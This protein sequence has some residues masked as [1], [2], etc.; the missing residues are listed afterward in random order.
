M[1]TIE[2]RIAPGKRCAAT[3]VEFAFVAPI[4]FVIVFGIIEFSR[5]LMV[6]QLLSELAVFV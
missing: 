3:L 4:L 2:T 1:S 6:G 5:G